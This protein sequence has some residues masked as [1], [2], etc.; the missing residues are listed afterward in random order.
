MDVANPLGET[1]LYHS[2]TREKLR[3]A[4]VI[5]QV[6]LPCHFASLKRH[7]TSTAHL[8]K[9]A[10]LLGTPVADV[11]CTAPPMETFRDL[12]RAFRQGAAATGGLELPA[13]NIG[14][15]KA[16]NMLWCLGEA[17]AEGNRKSISESSVLCLMRD[18]RHG[19]LHVRFRAVSENLEVVSGYL[20]Q[21]V[22]HSQDALSILQATS[23]ICRQA[24]MRN[25][26]PPEESH[27][28]E[29]FDDALF[30]HMREIIEA[31]SVDSASNEVAAVADM[32]MSWHPDMPK[33]APNCKHLLRDSA[34]SARRLLERLWRADEVGFLVCVCS[35]A[36]R[37]DAEC[38]F[39]VVLHA[40]A[41]PGAR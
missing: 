15:K 8:Q 20:G 5:C 12:L 22:G 16:N 25:S 2:I 4:C 33:F 26:S 37:F 17:L 39:L 1:W 32:S 29:V 35:C 23:D 19:R 3:C 28:A 40:G 7:H 27:L 38:C 18:E 34:H 36:M 24:C 30:E 11:A 9:I 13:G 6:E 41:C 31:I 14:Q 21:S 10:A